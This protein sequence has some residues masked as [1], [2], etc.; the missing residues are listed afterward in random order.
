MED[1]RTFMSID[2]G[3]GRSKLLLC[4]QRVADYEAIAVNG[5]HREIAVPVYYLNSTKPPQQKQHISTPNKAKFT[6]S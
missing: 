3:G 1:T 6:K 4:V 5:V 2:Q